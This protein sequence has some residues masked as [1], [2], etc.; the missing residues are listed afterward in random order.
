MVE[1]NHFR[2][3]L[4]LLYERG[5]R[6]ITVAELID[7]KINLPVGQSPVVFTFD[8]A[9]PSQFSYIEKDGELAIDPNSVVGIWL[10]FRRTHPDWRNKAVFCMLPAAQA[11]RSLFGDKG[12]EGQKTEWRF[13]KLQ[14][15]NAQGFELCNH[16]L[17]HARLDRAGDRVQEFIARG[18]MA[19]DSAVPG[20]K[21]RTM[22]LPLG[23]WPQNRELARSGAW[24]D[25]KSGQTVRYNYDAILEGS[26][27]P[28]RS[29]Y[30][31]KFDAHHLPR[32]EVFANE[33][34]KLLDQLERGGRY[35]SDGIPG[36][37]ARPMP[38]TA[39]LPRR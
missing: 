14:F 17:Y 29:P 19:I 37:V 31:P 28:A 35:I 24:Y 22:A 32:V 38:T 15:L 7:K 36:N 5:Y 33:L 23:L 18:N 13:K 34:E 16:T 8:D 12:I 10:E 20:Y 4:E 2:R 39:E 26:G 25:S 30:D 3:H 21:I 6:P 27:G 9:S 1:R 11:G